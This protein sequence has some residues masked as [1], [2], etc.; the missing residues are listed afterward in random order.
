[1][2][3]VKGAVLRYMRGEGQIGLCSTHMWHYTVKGNCTILMAAGQ[4]G[5]ITL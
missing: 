4:V 3:I 1:M 2:S 5:L